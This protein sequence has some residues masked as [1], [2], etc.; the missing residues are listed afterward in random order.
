MRRHEQVEQV[1]EWRP[2]GLFCCVSLRVI[3]LRQSR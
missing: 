3:P 2:E 1:L